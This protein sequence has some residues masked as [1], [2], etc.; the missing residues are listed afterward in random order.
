MWLSHFLLQYLC[1]GGHG[2][3]IVWNRWRLVGLQLESTKA[4]HEHELH[5]T[6]PSIAT[7][8]NQQVNRCNERV[9]WVPVR[10]L[11]FVQEPKRV[12][13]LLNCTALP[14]VGRPRLAW[15]VLFK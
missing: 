5:L 9:L 13:I 2:L 8:R 15:L 3:I 11:W 1:G 4:L 6:N 12:R 14:K 10:H 7:L